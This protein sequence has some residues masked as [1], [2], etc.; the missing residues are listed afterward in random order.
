MRKKT[1][2]K[3]LKKLN[4]YTYGMKKSESIKQTLI[5][6]SF[7]NSNSNLVSSFYKPISK[8]IKVN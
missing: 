3:V 5:P 1:S 4:L 6:S 2:F 7:Y 8:I